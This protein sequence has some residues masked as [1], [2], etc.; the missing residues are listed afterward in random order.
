[1]TPNILR[2]V[3]DNANV[4]ETLKNLPISGSQF[5]EST[6]PSA[7]A[8]AVLWEWQ[9]GEIFSAATHV[10]DRRFDMWEN[11]HRVRG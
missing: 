3:V 7:I 10:S 6:Y 9:N 11:C 2:P 4:R 1:M 5:V 8:G